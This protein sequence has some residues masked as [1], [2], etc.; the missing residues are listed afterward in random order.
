L[1][2][3]HLGPL[4]WITAQQFPVRLL[5]SVGRA[6]LFLQ[7]RLAPQRL[8]RQRPISARS[9]D[10]LRIQRDRLFQIAVRVFLHEAALIKLLRTLRGEA[11]RR[12]HHEQTGKHEVPPGTLGTL[13]T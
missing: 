9:L 4:F 10:H 8:R 13:G 12:H 3:G 2:G 1:R 11:D 7:P 5:R 6:Q